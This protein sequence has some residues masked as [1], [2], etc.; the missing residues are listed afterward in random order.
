M[1]GEKGRCTV[2]EDAH[3]AAFRIFSVINSEDK[4]VSLSHILAD[5][6]EE[7]INIC[8]VRNSDH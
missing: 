8:T 2:V 5:M 6:G 4:F 3:V 1:E 7:A